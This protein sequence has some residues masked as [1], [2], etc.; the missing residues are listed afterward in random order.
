[1]RKLLLRIMGAL[2]CLCVFLG[3]AACKKDDADSEARLT[4]SVAS[5]ELAVGDS[6]TLQITTRPNGEDEPSFSSSDTE[7]ATVSSDG[8]VEGISVGVATITVTL[9]EESATCVVTVKEAPSGDLAFLSAETTVRV[10]GSSKQLTL[11]YKGV[12]VTENVSY[13]VADPTVASV[14]ANGNVLG[15]KKGET[16]VTATYEGLT[17]TCKIIVKSI[18]VLETDK[19][20]VLIKPNESATITASAFMGAELAAVEKPQVQ[21]RSAD[22]AIATVTAENGVATITGVA[23]GVTVI[24]AEYEETSVEINVGV[25]KTVT[26]YAEFLALAQTRA[27]YIRLGADLDLSEATWSGTGDASPVCVIETF[28]GIL[29]GNGYKMTGLQASSSKYS[30]QTQNVGFFGRISDAA[31]IKNVIF[32]GSLGYTSAW[33]KVTAVRSRIGIF[34]WE[35]AGVIENCYIKGDIYTHLGD[36]NG[37]VTFLTS[38][39]YRNK[40]TIRNTLTDISVATYNTKYKA[41]ARKF[42]FAALNQGTIEN[43]VTVSSAVSRTNIYDWMSSNLSD[44]RT[45]GE[46]GVADY[47]DSSVAAPDGWSV[48]NLMQSDSGRSNSYIF[49]SYADLLSGDGYGYASQTEYAPTTSATAQ[50]VLGS[51]WS[52]GEK[53]VSLNDRE[54]FRDLGVSF[55]GGVL[56]WTESGSA[57]VLVGGKTLVTTE[58]TA[59]IFQYFEE[60]ASDLDAG[61]QTVQLRIA[62]VEYK[63]TFT[64]VKATTLADIV[65]YAADKT[66]YI[67]LENDIDMSEA[68]WIY[69]GTTAANSVIVSLATTLD[70]N[71]KKLSVLRHMDATSG[72]SGYN[73]GF[74]G[75]IESGAKVRNVIFSATNGYDSRAMESSNSPLRGRVGIFAYENA[76]LIENCYIKG[77]LR[78]H[79]GSNNPAC[80]LYGAVYINSGTMKNTVTDISVAPYSTAAKAL[81][82]AQGNARKFGFAVLNSG[83]IQNCVTVSSAATTISGGATFYDWMSAVPTENVEAFSTSSYASS[84]FSEGF[85]TN[86]VAYAD[87][88][89]TDSYIFTSYADLASS[90]GTG[91]GY[92]SSSAYEQVTSATA[93]TK[94]GE[95]WTYDE[96]TGKVMLKGVAVGESVWKVYTDTVAFDNGDVKMIAHRGQSYLELENTIPAFEAAATRSYHGMEADVRKTSDGKYIIAHDSNLRKIAGKNLVVEETTFDELRALR[97]PELS[98]TEE[99]DELF[100]PTIEEWLAVC[101]EYNKEALLEFK[102]TYTA[103]EVQEVAAIVE[104]AGWLENTVFIS[105]SQDDLLNLRTGYPTA[106]AMLVTESVTTDVIDWLIENQIGA[107]I[108]YWIISESLVTRLHD[109]GL[110]VGAWTVDTVEEAERLKACGVDYITT[111]ILE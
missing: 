69:N 1:M 22:P 103:E 47:V 13:A 83:A 100:L 2:T 53:T 7:I 105:Y 91:Y 19:T 90:A 36:S 64:L 12:K 32:E 101:K 52:F 40:G 73:V 79:L 70:G 104:E 28:K 33:K 88:G 106:R 68:K 78:S 29:D 63:D 89:R 99:R 87:G 65:K 81:Q 109:E 50:A 108:G 55:S 84:T 94:L 61:D 96:A 51:A 110:E 80:Y 23:G 102:G 43:C 38:A 74:I 49:T 111:N 60:N 75:K 46:F 8:V 11:F 76:G 31:T 4:L 48:H 72:A 86:R 30:P 18:A 20:T 15:L 24:T 45:G 95:A 71:G 67:R 9:G 107:S 3:V 21:F 26:S 77:V 16:T 10:E 39:V 59:D 5:Y 62:G 85:G 17:A 93:Q 57:T 66:A 92:K 54:V 82:V 27:P 35:N 37:Q 6:F 98:G 14:D 56:S 97:M 25:E 41:N 44:E 58:Q 34:A 42:G